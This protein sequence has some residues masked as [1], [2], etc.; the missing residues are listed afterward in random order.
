[1]SRIGVLLSGCG[2]YDGAEIHESVI[3]L[4]AL[5]RRG[6]QVVVLAPEVPQ[7]E[8]IDHH[9]GKPVVGESRSV[10]IEAARIARGP[11]LTPD[12]AGALD[13]LILPGGFG[14]AKNLSDFAIR[15]VAC[16]VE[17]ATA[18]LVRRMFQEGKPVGAWCIAPV[19]VIAAT[20][21]GE[22]RVR[23]TIGSD[24]GTAEAVEAMGA[25]HISCEMDGVVVDERH[26]L[27]TT[28]AYMLE[29][30]IAQVADGIERAV[31]AFS[32]LL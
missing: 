25:E 30:N 13:G 17:P 8:V 11:V 23:L 5:A 20:L 3:T 21:R 32:N 26:K 31:E 4:I 24:A 28:P 22:P 12:D 7:R 10:R 1:M 14:A 27:V 19:A 9:R 2:V 6:H 16:E 29:G 18:A 15:G